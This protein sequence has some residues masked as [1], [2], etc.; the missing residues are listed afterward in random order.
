M[1]TTRIST[2]TVPSTNGTAKP[3]ARKYPLGE[4]PMTPPVARKP[5]KAAVVRMSIR[6]KMAIVVGCVGCTLL[7]TSL[8]HCTEALCVLTGTP[9]VLAF[10]IAVGIDCG[11]VACEVSALV[12]GKK[13]VQWCHRV[14]GCS[15]ALSCLLNAVASGSHA[16]GAI[17]AYCVGGV[18]PLFVFMLS[19]VFGHLWTER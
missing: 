13:A 6:R 12:G 8:W 3:R 14:V 7:A 2:H 10:L 9:L 15:I 19:K 5:R 18:L 16:S 17:L 4:A 1:T 11:L